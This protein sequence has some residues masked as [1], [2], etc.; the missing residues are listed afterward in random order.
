MK[1]FSNIR[2]R[3]PNEAHQTLLTQQ[4]GCVHSFGARGA[5]RAVQEGATTCM[6]RA[7]VAQGGAMSA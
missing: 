2:C 1:A 3:C 6:R 4:A 5:A 7:H